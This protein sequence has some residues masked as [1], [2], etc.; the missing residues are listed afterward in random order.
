[1]TIV[2]NAEKIDLK[3]KR[4]KTININ[5][6]NNKVNSFSGLLNNRRKKVKKNG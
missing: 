1:M 2:K 3:P 4:R 6:E 5:S